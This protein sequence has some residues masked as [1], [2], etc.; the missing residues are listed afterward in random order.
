M[1]GREGLKDGKDGWINGWISGWWMVQVS[2]V[3]QQCKASHKCNIK[4]SSSHSLKSKYKQVKL[5]LKTFYLTQYIHIMISMHDQYKK[6][7]KW[8]GLQSF[9]FGTVFEIWC[10]FYLPLWLSLDLAT[11]WVLKSHQ[12]LV[13]N[14]DVNSWN[15]QDEWMDGGEVYGWDEWMDGWQGRW[16]V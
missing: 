10:V 14:R 12:W 2:T 1:E 3:P 8:D 4:F 13:V 15:G 16:V 7:H 11:F 9:F 5:I 6:N